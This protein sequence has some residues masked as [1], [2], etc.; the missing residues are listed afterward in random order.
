M[1]PA[2]L[3]ESPNRRFS[4]F[5]SSSKAA[6]CTESLLSSHTKFSCL[7]K[8]IHSVLIPWQSISFYFTILLIEYTFQV[9]YEN[10]SSNFNFA[11]T[12]MFIIYSY[13]I[14]PPKSSIK[15]LPNPNLSF[16]FY[17]F[18]LLYI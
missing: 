14:H 7:H 8:A 13:Q 9:P 17:Q 10:P 1:Q 16:F 3:F 2:A 5:V 12:Y 11:T 6:P 18:F 4:Q 15:V